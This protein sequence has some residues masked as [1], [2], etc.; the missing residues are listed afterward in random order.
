MRSR[1]ASGHDVILADWGVSHLS[2]PGNVG[3]P[4]VAVSRVTRVPKHAFPTEQVYG[5]TDHA[6][7]RLITCGGTY[8]EKRHRYLENVVVYARRDGRRTDCHGSG[9]PTAH[10]SMRRRTGRA[11]T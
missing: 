4:P 3:N 8:L 10:G 2:R 9:W 6:A 5:H 11:V 1:R 7:L